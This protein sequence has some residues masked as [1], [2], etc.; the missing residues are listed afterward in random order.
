MPARFPAKVKTPAAMTTPPDTERPPLPAVRRRLI[1]RGRTALIALLVLSTLLAAGAAAWFWRETVELRANPE[2]IIE[3][4]NRQ[5][6]EKIG[7]LTPLPEN[8][9]PT[10]ATVSD[11]APL[12]NQ[13]FFK[14][15]KL[16]DK[17]IIYSISKRAILYDPAGDKLVEV[18]SLEKP[19]DTPNPAP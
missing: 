9:T 10:I 11:L 13:V 17:V 4:N 2:K 3:E 5:L 18:A 7:R 12:Q 15:A 16:G 8:E 1:P 6:L 19:P 14:N